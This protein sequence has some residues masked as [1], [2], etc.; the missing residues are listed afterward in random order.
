MHAYTAHGKFLKIIIECWK[1]LEWMLWFFAARMW[2]NVLPYEPWFVNLFGRVN[3]CVC[4][5]NYKLFVLLV[6]YSSLF[7]LF[8]AATTLQYFV[9]FWIV[10]RPLCFD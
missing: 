4:F 9:I 8:L 5:D 10:S 3:S 7:S 1:T 2:W 6:A